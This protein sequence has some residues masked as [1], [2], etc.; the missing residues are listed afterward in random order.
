MKKERSGRI[1]NTALI[2]L[3]ILS[4]FAIGGF[5]L[6]NYHI[7]QE[8]FYKGTTINGIDVGGL[9]V[10]DASNVVQ[11][12]FNSNIKNISITLTYNNKSWNYT[13]A[14]FEV[15][16]DLT[17]LIQQAYSNISSSNI[18]ERRIKYKEHKQNEGKINL[19]YRNMLGGF[20]E[21][22]DL[23]SNEIYQEL[24]EPTV[25]FDPS[26]D[27]IFTYIEGQSEITV[28]RQELESLID[29][30]FML[31][32]NISVQIPTLEI[33]PE[34]TIN[35]LK[36]RTKLRSEFSTSYSSS[37][38]NRK[39]NVKQA[40]KAFNGKI[41][42]PQEEVSFNATTGARTKENG[43]K[44][45]NIILNGMYV[46]G[47]G[48]G[49]CQAST[50]LYNALL[51]SNL[52]ILEVSKH[53]LPAS[54][55]PLGFDAM[56]SEGVAD[57]KFKNNTTQPIYIKAWGDNTNANVQIYGLGFDNGEYFKTRS[58][59][60]KTIPHLG[61]RIVQDTSGEY[62]N[63]VTFKG[64]YLRLK[65]PHEGYEANAYLQRYSVDGELLEE[66]LI[67]HEIYEPQEGIIIEGIEDIYDGITLPKNDVKFIPPQTS[68]S[69]NKNNVSN[70]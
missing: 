27:Q 49:V 10:T 33:A 8:E 19:S 67:R 44:P 62:S 12:N 52:E 45:A 14:D 1:V 29:N 18:F 56:V 6:Y 54:Y 26:S 46:E 50:T 16:D 57:L 28:D 53:S 48:G 20:S 11:T 47:S 68:S 66:K 69:T 38:K 2:L 70:V 7:S 22:L 25:V 9:N 5:A 58:E 35:N 39:N 40:L 60:V 3:C 17:P 15:V 59:F 37:T 61:D 34:Q 42:M 4:V 36:D 21:K 24:K 63:K 55:V 65:Y 30:S 64:E 41:V 31:S 51:L 43:Y 32:K 13:S 23:I